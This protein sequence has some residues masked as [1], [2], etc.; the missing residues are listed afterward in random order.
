MDF[1]RLGITEGS[2]I[3][4]GFRVGELLGARTA[5]VMRL[6]DRMSGQLV[7]LDLDAAL[8]TRVAGPPP[9]I[10]HSGAVAVWSWGALSAG[11]GWLITAE[12]VGP[13]LDDVLEEGPMPVGRAV[14]VLFGIV[15]ALRAVHARGEPLLNLRPRVIRLVPGWDRDHVRI[16]STP[17]AIGPAAGQPLLGYCAPE[18]AW[19]EPDLTADQYSLGVIAYELLVGTPPHNPDAPPGDR[20]LISVRVDD[21][22]PALDALVK[23]LLAEEPRDRYGGLDEV[24]EVLAALRESAPVDDLPSY[25]SFTPLIRQRETEPPA[26]PAA[27]LPEGPI[28]VPP[29]DSVLGVLLVL[30]SVG[31]TAL[32]LS[33]ALTMMW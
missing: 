15:D 27:P 33:Y 13:S 18:L 14:E 28:V 19:G 12:P 8:A 25:G 30:I 21:A 20:T 2:L 32:A 6:A 11:A 31:A 16:P 7:L 24:A 10:A 29:S 1:A 22:P 9:S 17:I 26:P 4:S 5:R 3:G 23:R